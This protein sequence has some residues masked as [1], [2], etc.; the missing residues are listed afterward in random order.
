[1]NFTPRPLYFHWKSPW[2]PLDKRLGGSRSRSGH[3]AEE[4]NCQH[5]PGMEPPFIQSVAQ[6]CHC[7]YYLND[8]LKRLMLCNTLRPCDSGKSLCF[9][10]KVSYTVN[11]PLQSAGKTPVGVIRARVSLSIHGTWNV[12]FNPTSLDLPIWKWNISML[13]WL[14]R[15]FNIRWR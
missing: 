2:N 15:S 4:K 10:N 9:N 8:K 11:I 12:K 14:R 5:L 3:S 1:M 6:L 7:S 13:G